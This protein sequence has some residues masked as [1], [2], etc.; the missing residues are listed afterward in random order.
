MVGPSPLIFNSPLLNRPVLH[1]FRG[2]LGDQVFYILQVLKGVNVLKV[3]AGD[4]PS[5]K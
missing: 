3:F 4:A 2:V 5:A 1:V